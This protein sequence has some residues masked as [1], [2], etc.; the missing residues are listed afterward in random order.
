MRNLITDLR[1][2]GRSLARSRGLSAVA[3]ISLALGSGAVTAAFALVYGI[4]LQPLPYPESARLVAVKHSAPGLGLPVTGFSD[5]TYFH[6]RDHSQSFQSL[7]TYSQGFRNLT[8]PDGGTER[9]ELTYAG[10]ELFEVLGVRPVLGR[11]F[12]AADGQPGFGDM[13]WPVPVLLSHV[14][15]RSHYGGDPGIV[16]QTI[17]L[18]DIPRHVM[19]V[20]PAGF[21]FPR[22]ETQ[23]WMLLMASESNASFANRFDDDAVGRLMP[24]VSPA[25]AERELARILPSIEGVYSDATRERIDEV[26]LRPIVVPLKEEVVGPVSTALWLVFGGMTFLLLVASANVAGLFFVRAQRADHEV[27]VRSALGARRSDLIRLFLS[28]AFLLSVLGMAIGLFIAYAA[29]QAATTW[30]PVRLPRLDEVGLD[31]WVLAFAAGSAAMVALALGVLSYLRQTL[32]NASATV[33]RAGVGITETPGRLRARNALVALQVA[34]VLVLLVGSG[35][36]VQSLWRLT[37]VDPGFDST[38]LL[39]VEIGL[40]G[41][42]A[43]QHAQIYGGLLDRVRDLPGVVSASAASSLPMDQTAYAFPFLVGGATNPTEE[44]LT[45]KFVMPG[46][47]ETMKTPLIA[48]TSLNPDEPLSLPRGVV[49]S[50]ALARRYFPGESPIGR[51]IERLESDGTPV[52]MYDRA[53]RAEQ[54]SPPWT[55]VGVVA[56]VPEMTLREGARPVVY[57]PVRVPRIE[58]SISPINATLVI[59]TTAVSLGAAVRQT[60]REFE[61]TIS[62]ARIRPMDAI[63]TNSFA[64]E[65]LLGVLLLAA[66]CISL[67]LGAIGVYGITAQ[68][69]RQRQQEV[70]VR[71]ALGAPPGRLLRMLMMDPLVSVLTGLAVGLPVAFAAT[72]GL[73]SLLFEVSATDPLTYLAATVVLIAVATV[74]SLPA[75]LRAVRLSPIAALRDQ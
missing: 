6:Y 71:I 1:H 61:P 48:G 41:R 3:L 9:V 40:S 55:I 30:T 29:I 69:V 58:P 20:L 38:G 16:D 50:R 34:L 10:P 35:L 44:P 26:Q 24:G 14:F 70:G 73:R 53:A 7:A 74:A 65:R 21:A 42:R 27:A 54:P 15:W 11:L 39:T 60:I 17:I 66:A 22:R 37:R 33:L 28:E 13:T 25:R 45:M 19:G 51:T 56:D 75:S 12:T 36:M 47:F 68:S 4:L 63:V 64:R 72:R 2:A 59:R 32:L 43:S 5:G 57:V 18:N 67:F 49:V 52:A 62:V 31:R 23:I 8:L 46:Y